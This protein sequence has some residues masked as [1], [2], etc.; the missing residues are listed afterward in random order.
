MPRHGSGRTVYVEGHGN[1][2]F[3]DLSIKVFKEMNKS[4]KF[5]IH[6]CEVAE[7]PSRVTKEF[8]ESSKPRRPKN[9]KVVGA[10]YDE[11]PPPEPVVHKCTSRY[12]DPTYLPGIP[13][14]DLEHLSDERNTGAARSDLS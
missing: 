13:W 8:F 7:W 11:A 1:V 10:S 9:G 3:R 5:F 6:R 2:S 14:G 12:S 4:H